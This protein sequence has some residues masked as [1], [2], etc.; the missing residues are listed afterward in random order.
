MTQICM[1]PT[2]YPEANAVLQALLAGVQSVL[3]ERLVGLYVHGSLAGGDFDPQRSD[4]DFL[5][6]TTDELPG[7]VLAAL[8][9]MHATHLRRMTAIP[10]R[11]RAAPGMDEKRGG[12]P[13]D[14]P[15]CPVYDVHT[16]Q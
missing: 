14:V 13:L 15:E 4:V 16:N 12:R 11:D 5:V 3:G 8:E 9:A 2:P 6:V 1:H 10:W 7:Q